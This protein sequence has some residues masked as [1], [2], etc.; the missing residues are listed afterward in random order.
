MRTVIEQFQH[1]PASMYLRA[2]ESPLFTL[3]DLLLFSPLVETLI[4]AAIIETARLFHAPTLLQILASVLVLGL[5]HSV[6]WSPRGLILTPGFAVMAYSYVLWRSTSW[7]ISLLIVMCTH[8]VY[9]LIPT[10]SVLGYTLR[11]HT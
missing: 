7:K 1:P 2:R 3:G 9:N 8:A 4:L 10:I 11:H 6:P 5:Y